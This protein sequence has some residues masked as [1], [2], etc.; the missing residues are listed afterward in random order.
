MIRVGKMRD[1]GLVAGVSRCRVDGNHP[2]SSIQIQP[3]DL[4]SKMIYRKA[5]CWRCPQC[6]RR[7][8][9]AHW[10]EVVAEHQNQSDVFTRTRERKP[11]ALRRLILQEREPLSL[12]SSAASAEVF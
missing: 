3:Q 1:Q 4:L 9:A 5:R 10:R 12:R 7:S 11:C 6:R 2:L 8:K